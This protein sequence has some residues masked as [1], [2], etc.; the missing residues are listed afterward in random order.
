M[1]SNNKLKKSSIEPWT[2]GEIIFLGNKKIISWTKLNL[3]KIAS[4]I[5]RLLFDMVHT[6]RTF[7]DSFHFCF[8][9]HF[10]N[11]SLAKTLFFK[12]W[13]ARRWKRKQWRG[14]F[15][16]EI[17]PLRTE[18]I[19]PE[20]GPIRA[21]RRRSWS[22]WRKIRTEKLRSQTTSEIRRPRFLCP[23]IRAGHYRST[24]VLKKNLYVW[25]SDSCS[26][27]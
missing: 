12:R 22:W 10:S 20:H 3:K 5:V 23:K 2:N 9:F 6:E 14:R 4:K 18:A 13:W 17:V 1:W 16:S 11:H 15:C 24:Q 26:Q 7:S 21:H 25:F 8:N 27:W 19:P